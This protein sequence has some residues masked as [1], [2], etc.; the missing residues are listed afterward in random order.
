MVEGITNGNVEGEYAVI[1]MIGIKA[2]WQMNMPARAKTRSGK[3]ALL[4]A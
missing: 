1:K 4:K 2:R 3:K